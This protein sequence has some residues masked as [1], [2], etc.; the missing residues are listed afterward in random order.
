[1]NLINENTNVYAAQWT[2]VRRKRHCMHKQCVN[3]KW[4]SK[5][6][7][8]LYDYCGIADQGAGESCNLWLPSGNSAMYHFSYYPDHLWGPG[9]WKPHLIPLTT[10]TE[11]DRALS[12]DCVLYKK[13]FITILHKNNRQEEPSKRHTYFLK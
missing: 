6:W 12:T 7:S 4:L 9:G 13:Q 2:I 8:I 3:C 11:G 10:S 5:S 1:M